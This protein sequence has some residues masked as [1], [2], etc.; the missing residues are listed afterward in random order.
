LPRLAISL[1][2]ETTGL[3]PARDAILEIG[4]VKFRGDEVVEIYETLVNPGRLIPIQIT[5]LTGITQNEVDKKGISLFDALPRL[6]AF[7]GSL[8]IIGHNISFDLGFLNKQR[9]FTRNESIDTFELAGILVPHAGRY[10]LGAL[11]RELAIDLPATHRALDDA[12]V[13]HALYMKLFERARDLPAKTLEQILKLSASIEWP[14]RAFFDDALRDA[15][16]GS[17][18]GGSIGAQLA[19]KQLQRRRRAKP[20]T[21]LFARTVK[22]KPLRPNPDIQ[23]I[24]TDAIASALEHG[25]AFEQ[26]IEHFEH[27]PQ[28]VH[29][30]RAVCDAFNRSEHLLVE[31]GTGTGKSLAYLLPSIQWA[32]KN[33]ERVVIST[34]T[35]NL[36]EQLALKDV[37]DLQKAIGVE[38]RA[39]VLKG[40]SHYLCPARFQS[41][42]KAGPINADEMRVL[43]KVLFWMPNTVSGDGDELFLPTAA[44]RAVWGRLCADNPTCSSER[45]SA[46]GDNGCFFHNARQEAE[47][48]HVLIVNH[49]L[50]LADVAVANRALPEYK[51]LVVDEAHHLEAATTDQLSFSISR[52]ELNRMMDELSPLQ[53]GRGHGLLEDVIGRV[54]AS[55]PP[56]AAGR[57]QAY[58]EGAIVAAGEASQYAEEFFALVGDF[59]SQHVDRQSDYTQRLRLIPALRTQPAWSNVE[60]A[61]DNLS[62]QIH[63]LVDALDRLNGTVKELE[64]YEIPDY[65][66]VY[67]RLVGA[68]RALDEA[69]ANTN[70]VVSQPTPAGI[71]WIEVQQSQSGRSSGRSMVSLHSAPL[72]VGPLVEQHLFKTKNSVVLT[73]ATLRTGKSFNF[74]QSRLNAQDIDT[75]AVGSPFDYKGSTLLYLASDLPE[76]NAP[77]YQKAIEIGLIELCKA[78]GGRTLV[79]FTSYAQLR[80]TSR[81]IVPALA[82]HDIMVFEQTDG[83]SRRQLLDRF[84]AAERGV[85]MG[86]RSFWEG[87]DVPGEALSCLAITRLPFAVPTDPIFAARSETFEQSFTE[88]AVPDAVL[89]FRQ[90]FGRLIRT[91]TDRGVVAIFDRRVLTKQYGQMFLQ[92]L[93]DCSVV[94][95]PAAM[96][97]KTVREWMK[98][99]S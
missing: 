5:E 80:A 24:D 12:K 79:L 99:E 23:P 46:W 47:G 29:M 95:A 37:P 81:V 75:L 10:G 31:A 59:I 9:V 14:A 6:N 44:E 97:N 78:M 66:D 83:S 89:R 36:Q 63:T 28:Q 41:M 17:F 27:R 91:K 32:L 98:R 87:V 2:L 53:A 8:P 34:N 88:Y 35:I 21:P 61:W 15:T 13:T 33:G 84:K 54:R 73:S 7:V 51:Y 50:L 92:S 96:L 40:R 72:H 57:V 67:A 76:P 93:P 74:I 45:C 60:I 56:D 26:T 4:A 55:C 19:A 86:T 82:Q 1:D 52:Y 90:G 38:F 20:D 68:R 3:D 39:A 62:G 71:Y 69:R 30:L 77:G 42:L 94:R 25:G 18:S 70:A 16:R 65:D 49:A 43:A 11:A 58:G 48:A 64:E 22:V 85:L